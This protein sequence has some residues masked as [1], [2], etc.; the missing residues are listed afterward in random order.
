MIG[1][2]AWLGRG[3]EVVRVRPFNHTGPGQRPD[4]VV[5]SLARQIAEAARTGAGRL[6]VGNLDT[7]RDITD[8]RDVV[9]AYRCLM[10][11]GAPGEVYNV[12]RGESVVISDV[13]RRLLELAGMDIPLVVDPGRLRSVDLPDLR[14]DSTRL[15]AATGWRPEIE[16]DRTLADVLESFITAGAG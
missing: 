14:G 8:V 2:Q 5:P 12:C 9:R 3:T 4:F 10:T 16:I 1:L 7:R 6:L 13:A 15:R 11:A